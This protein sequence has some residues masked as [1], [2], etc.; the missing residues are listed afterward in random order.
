MW[1]R[2][3]LAF[4]FD[5]I[6]EPLVR[7]SVPDNNKYA[8]SSNYQARI[9]ATEAQLKKYSEII[10]LDSRHYSRR[11]LGLGVL[12]CYNGNVRK[13]RES[14]LRGIKINPFEPRN[15]FNLCLS[16]LGA[17]NFKKWKRLK[18]TWLA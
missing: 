12:H 16:V 6:K 10:A 11:Y 17:K 18:E 3:A 5:Y 15:Y 14:F 7:Y 8:L 2:I 4:Q 9:K 1:V 13:G